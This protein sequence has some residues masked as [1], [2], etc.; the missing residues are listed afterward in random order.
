MIQIGHKFQYKKRTLKNYWKVEISQSSET[1]IQSRNAV[2]VTRSDYW[3][4]F[5]TQSDS[6]PL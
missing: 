2:P 1:E 4:Q 5:G 3:M 6:V